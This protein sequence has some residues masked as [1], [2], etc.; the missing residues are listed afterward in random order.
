MIAIAPVPCAEPSW[1][2]PRAAYVHVPFCAHKCGYCDFASLAGVDHLADRYLT[3]LEREIEMSLA[4]PQEVETIFVGGGTPTRLDAGQLSR[5][6]AIIRRWLI[7]APGGEWTVEANPGTLDAEKADVLVEAGVNRISLGAQSFQAGLLR[8]LERHHGRAEV[9]QAVEVV[10]PRFPHWSLDLIFGVP[11]STISD[12]SDDLETALGFGPAH[13]S[14]YG[15]VFEKGTALWNQRQSGRVRPI[16]EDVERQMYETTIDRL[17]AAGLDM[18]E[19]SNFARPGHESRHNLAYWANDAYFG[20][21]VGAAR[22]LRG[23]RSVN[24]RDLLAYLRRIES[25]QSATGPCEELAAEARARETAILM[26]RRIRIGIARDDFLRRTGFELDAL[27][28]TTVL[29]FTNQGCL[30]DDGQRVRLSREGLF[31]ADRVL[32]ELL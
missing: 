15:L 8:V 5:L 7:L 3:A 6:T 30:E 31:V 24:T 10:R 12:W 23:V 19:I 25:G 17:T 21:G 2:W 18:Y 4:E 26:L 16:D 22:Y 9:E 28:G 11:G 29:R 14:C 20:F 27:A 32:C 1:R 13:L